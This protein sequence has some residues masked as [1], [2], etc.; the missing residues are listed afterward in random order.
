M[1]C[2]VFTIAALMSF[3]LGAEEL[4]PPPDNNV[5]NPIADPFAASVR[6]VEFPPALL[7][8]PSAAD[9]PMPTPLS[10]TALP[11]SLRVAMLRRGGYGLLISAETGTNLIPVKD[12]GTLLLGGQT[13]YVEVTMDE[14]NL[15]RRPK[16]MP[17]W[18]GTLESSPN[19]AFKVETSQLNFV[20]PLSAG[21]NP[22]LR[23]SHGSTGGTVA[24]KPNG[25]L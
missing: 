5:P 2:Y 8:K 4:V 17:V 1:R 3:A 15:M 7:G 24:P 9:F 6:K 25:P 22:G 13:Y 19:T 20:P 21:V 18:T 11:P 16:G 23:S 12:K 10:H 14:V